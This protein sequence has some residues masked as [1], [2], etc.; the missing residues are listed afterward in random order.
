MNE[1]GWRWAAL[2]SIGVAVAL[3]ALLVAGWQVYSSLFTRE[4]VI[5]TASLTILRLERDSQLVTTRAFV[6]QRSETWYGNAEIIR[7]IPATVH[8]AVNLAEIDRSQMKYDEAKHVLS[9]PL[10]DVKVIAIDPDL[11]H[12]ETIR[13][14]D[15]LRTEGGAGNQLEEAT[16]KMVRPTLEKIGNS[17]EAVKVAKDQ[18]IASVGKLLES[19][20][21]ATGRSVE[22]RP[23]FRSDGNPPM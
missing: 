3:L 8:Y 10:P 1:K 15:L 2:T 13:S 9:V 16:E 20:F 19:A 18:A 23:W 22:V 17:P 4:N 5:Q 11:Q 21:A 14:L 6:R 12:A 7:I